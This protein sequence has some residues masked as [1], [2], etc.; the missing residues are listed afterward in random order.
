M[1]DPDATYRL[2]AFQ[3]LRLLTALQGGALPWSAIQEGFTC[4]AERV[5]FASAA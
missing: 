3:R 2:A 1:T 4:G 5:L